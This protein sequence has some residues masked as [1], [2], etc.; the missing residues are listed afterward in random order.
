M[1]GAIPPIKATGFEKEYHEIQYYARMNRKG[2]RCLGTKIPI[3][4]SL[5]ALVLA[6]AMREE[7]SALGRLSSYEDVRWNDVFAGDH[8][9]SIDA[10]FYLVRDALKLPV[11][12]E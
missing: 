12:T 2:R 4:Q 9:S 10:V 1:I 7:K 11:G 3:D 6:K 5:W 8:D